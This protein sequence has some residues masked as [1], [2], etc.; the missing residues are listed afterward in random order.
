MA[1]LILNNSNNVQATVSIE[2]R[3]PVVHSSDSAFVAE[4][5][6]ISKSFFKDGIIIFSEPENVIPSTIEIIRKRIFADNPRFLKWL[7]KELGKLGYQVQYKIEKKVIAR[8]ELANEVRRLLNQLP[9]EE[10]EA[11]ARAIIWS[12]IPKMTDEQLEIVKKDL[13][14]VLE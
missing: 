9:M 4:I 8:K 14:E 13:K 7:G 12:A 6:K 5:K 10:E 11:K 2:N 1:Y 3:E